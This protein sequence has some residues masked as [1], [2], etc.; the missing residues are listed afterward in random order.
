M[1]KVKRMAS[2]WGLMTA[3]GLLTGGCMA[4][5]Q[6]VEPMSTTPTADQ[7][8]TLRQVYASAFPEARVGVVVSVLPDEPYTLVNE[9]DTREIQVGQIVSFIDAAE[10]VIAHGEVVKVDP[11][12]LA[13]RFSP[14]IRA[15]QVGDAAVKF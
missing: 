14:V 8:S 4:P 5:K 3:A 1:K 9:I 11:G 10:T 15:P 13:V 7:I 12:Q 6:S 2:V